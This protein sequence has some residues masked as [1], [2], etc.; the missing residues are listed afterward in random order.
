M[1][2]DRLQVTAGFHLAA[3]GERHAFRHGLRE[4]LHGER[5][6]WA[7]YERDTPAPRVELGGGHPHLLQEDEQGNCKQ[8]PLISVTYWTLV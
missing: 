7:N 3:L 6:H 5:D 4:V 8:L 1:A 2:R